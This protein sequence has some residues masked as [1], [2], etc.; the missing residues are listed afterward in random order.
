[1]GKRGSEYLCLKRADMGVWQGI[2]GGGEGSEAPL[3]AAIRETFEE[4]GVK[5]SAMVDLHSVAKLPVVDVVG[6][7]LWG[8]NV[9]EIPEFSFCAEVPYDTQIKL[10]AEHT[11]YKWCTAKEALDLLEWDSNKQAIRQAEKIR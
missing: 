6:S 4:T 9:A 5:T 3:A 7:Y 2:A 10:S 1:M 11:E 8:E